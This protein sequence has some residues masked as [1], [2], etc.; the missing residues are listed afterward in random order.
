VNTYVILA[1]TL[2][3]GCAV[4]ALIAAGHGG[5]REAMEA[6]RDWGLCIAANLLLGAIVGGIALIVWRVVH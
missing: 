4:T 5:R 6:I 3:S 1:L 2:V